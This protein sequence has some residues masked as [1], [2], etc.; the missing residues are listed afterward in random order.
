MIIPKVQM[1][2]FYHQHPDIRKSTF[3]GNRIGEPYCFVRK[4]TVINQRKGENKVSRADGMYLA[5]QYL[6]EQGRGV[7]YWTAGFNDPIEKKITDK[8]G[9]VDVQ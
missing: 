2:R 9:S 1:S 7:I 6:M 5:F 4:K 3:I 8:F